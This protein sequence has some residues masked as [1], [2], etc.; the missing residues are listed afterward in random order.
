MKT[1][2]KLIK[3]YSRK[4]SFERWSSL[5]S[6][7]DFLNA[8]ESGDFLTADVLAAKYLENNWRASPLKNLSSS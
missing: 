2:K 6:K 4:F 7:M 3:N 8:V 1:T 5:V